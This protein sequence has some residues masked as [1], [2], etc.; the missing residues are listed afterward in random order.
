MSEY[1]DTVERRPPS[2]PVVVRLPQSMIAKIDRAGRGEALT[3]SEAIRRLIALGLRAT[4]GD[5]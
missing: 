5:R 4:E 3:R 2:P 1:T